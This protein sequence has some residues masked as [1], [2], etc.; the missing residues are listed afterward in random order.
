[1]ASK[2]RKIEYNFEKECVLP[3]NQDGEKRIPFVL[4]KTEKRNIAKSLTIF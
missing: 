4:H 1:M 2:Q 3:Y